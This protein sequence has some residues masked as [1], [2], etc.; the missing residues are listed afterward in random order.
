MGSVK[1][2]KIINMMDMNMDISMELLEWKCKLFLKNEI[3][4][5]FFN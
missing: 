3:F 2:L 5:I 1:E 4:Y